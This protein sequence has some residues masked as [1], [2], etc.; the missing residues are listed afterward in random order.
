MHTPEN[1]SDNSQS[2]VQ[3][4]ELI[5]KFQ[6]NKLKIYLSQLIVIETLIKIIKQLLINMMK[7]LKQLNYVIMK[8]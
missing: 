5:L 1:D 3:G 2:S 6:T 8:S 7:S 4:E